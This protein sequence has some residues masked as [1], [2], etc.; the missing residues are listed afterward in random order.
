DVTVPVVVPGIDAIDDAGVAVSGALG[1]VSFPNVLINDTLGPIP[2]ATVAGQ[3]DVA[4]VSVTPTPV[5]GGVHLGGPGGV[6]VVVDPNT[7]PGDYVLEYE[8]CE[9][10]SMGANCDTAVVTVPVNMAILV[11]NDDTGLTLNGVVG[12]TSFTNILVNDTED[13]QPATVGNLDI[14]QVS[15]TGPY[16]DGVDVKVA[17]GT[18]AGAH[19]L[20]YEICISASA[21]GSCDEATVFVT[22]TAAAIDA[23]N[24][25]GASVIGVSG[26]QSIA[27]V[28]VNDT[29]NGA[30]TD[31][32]QVTL[33]YVS[34]SAGLSLNTATGA[35][36]VAPG[37]PASPVGVPY[38]L[39]YR[40][41][42]NLNTS[43]CDTAVVTVPVV[44][45]P[46]DAV[47]DT[48]N[49]VNGGSGGTALSSVLLNDTLNGVPVTLPSV[50]L[51]YISGTPGLTLDPVLASVWVWVGTAANPAA[52][53]TYQIC[54][55]AN[56]TNCDTA[57]VTVPVLAGPIEAWDDIAPSA[58]SGVAGGLAIT[59][60]LV[61]DLLNG[62][63]ATVANVTIAYVSGDAGLVLN[64]ATGA[65]TVT[66]GTPANPA[67]TLTYRICEILNPLNC[68]EADALAP[69]SAPP[70]DAV[71]DN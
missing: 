31:L 65:V 50:N 71:D 26:G 41:C 66:P 11:A 69:I 67:A 23:V 7:T 14:V 13:G 70:I 29:L 60:V 48:G 17:P 1:G 54:E 42:E 8:I 44:T 57:V 46:I 19:E 53:L 64:P 43:N 16:L 28:T 3:I 5:T 15:S 10:I 37:T 21:G 9:S 25:A 63:A 20:V 32:S 22:V 18:Q 24:D 55:K 39:T 47:D 59:N 2:A 36:S 58:V 40:I 52:T 51:T 12:G 30:P 56:P 27:N 34:G 49:P 35:V 62:A 61:N 6:S 68:A 4:E 38:T 33:S 45:A